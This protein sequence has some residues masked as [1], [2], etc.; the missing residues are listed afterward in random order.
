MKNKIYTTTLFSLSLLT[1]TLSASAQTYTCTDVGSTADEKAIAGPITIKLSQK[2]GTIPTGVATVTV[3]DGKKK[4][5]EKYQVHSDLAGYGLINIS[6]SSNGFMLNL[7]VKASESEIK[8][9]KLMFILPAD[10][11]V[12]SAMRINATVDCS[13]K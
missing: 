2:N 10:S 11:A 1:V 3:R 9:A 4:Q 7:D 5:V 6:N 13:K 8:N 12:L